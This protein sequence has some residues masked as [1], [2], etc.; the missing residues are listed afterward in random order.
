MYKLGILPVN[1]IQRVAANTHHLAI[2]YT[3]RGEP[4]E[5][6]SI[7]QKQF[8]QMFECLR[9]MFN[10]GIIHRD[11]TPHHF[12]V[13]K[14]KR[15]FVIDFGSAILISDDELNDSN[16]G[17]ELESSDPA[18]QNNYRGSIRFAATKILKCLIEK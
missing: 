15:I 16:L 2:V 14:D 3:P 9:S 4:L 17:K 12:L 7:T 11:L 10:K 5:N 13:T 1:F 6:Q 8:E 18:Y